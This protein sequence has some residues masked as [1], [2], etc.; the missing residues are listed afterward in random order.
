M[1]R[2]CKIDHSKGSSEETFLA[3]LVA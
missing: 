2:E 3:A 1:Y